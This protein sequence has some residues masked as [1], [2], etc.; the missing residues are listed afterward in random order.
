MYA[1]F[2]QSEDAEA[3]RQAV[4][5]Y[6]MAREAW[7][8]MASKAATVYQADVSY[9]STP[10]RRGHWSDRLPGIDTDLA[11]M[12]VKVQ[13]AS[14]GSGRNATEAIRAATGRPSRPHV[15]CLHTPPASF[16]PGQPLALSLM[17]S[18]TAGSSAP[19]AVRLYY[20]HVNQAERWTSVETSGQSSGYAGTIP[21]EYTDSIYPLQYYFQLE[22][23]KGLAW[24]YPGFNK[25]LSNQPYF[26]VYK[27]SA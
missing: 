18:V 12:Q 6:R 7:A 27:R 10:M 13:V 26:A 1:V 4:D 8:D 22:D 20:R 3:G 24:L 9:G 17:P 15:A 14:A 5:R 23:G 11:A 21:A 25:T 19:T 16:Q 2:E